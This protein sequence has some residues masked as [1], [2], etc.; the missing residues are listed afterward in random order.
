MHDGPASSMRHAEPM[1]MVIPKHFEDE[2]IRRD[3]GLMAASQGLGNLA[4]LRRGRCTPEKPLELKGAR[5]VAD[6][7]TEGRKELEAAACT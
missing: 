1:A 3:A 6:R 4:S 7:A 2:V 5:L